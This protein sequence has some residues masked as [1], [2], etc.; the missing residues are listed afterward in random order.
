MQENRHPVEGV[1][2]HYQTDINMGCAHACMAAHIH[3]T[4]AKSLYKNCQK[5]R[6]CTL[7]IQMLMTMPIEHIFSYQK[8]LMLRTEII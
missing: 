6:S 8:A 2:V 3:L 7:S 5:E 1:K 4:I